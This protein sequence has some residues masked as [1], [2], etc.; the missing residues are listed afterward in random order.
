MLHL[1]VWKVTGIL[2]EV[3]Y[4]VKRDRKKSLPIAYG[5]NADKQTSVCLC[6][7]PRNLLLSIRAAL[8]RLGIHG[9]VM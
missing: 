8:Q 7:F 4:T 9:L 6:A 2:S 1:S 5:I 3:K